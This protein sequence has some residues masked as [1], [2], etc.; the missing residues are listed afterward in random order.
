MKKFI[1]AM[2]GVNFLVYFLSYFD[3]SVLAKMD[4]NT[5]GAYFSLVFLSV[6]SLIVGTISIHILYEYQVKENNESVSSQKKI[7]RDS[8]RDDTLL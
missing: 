7:D 4:G 2:T 3:I 8:S 6:V 1:I 5:A